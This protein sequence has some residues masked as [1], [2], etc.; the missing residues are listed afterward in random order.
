MWVWTIFVRYEYLSHIPS[1]TDT[2]FDSNSKK[3]VSQ[4]GERIILLYVFASGFFV[5]VH[6]D[7]GH[8]E[9][10]L[11]F[12]LEY[13]HFRRLMLRLT[14]YDLMCL[15]ETRFLYPALTNQVH[16][17]TVFL[18]RWFALIVFWT[19]L[20]Y[21]TEKYLKRTKCPKHHIVLDLE[22]TEHQS[23][24]FDVERNLLYILR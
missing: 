15:Q 10:W 3:M 8:K 16:R 5:E 9:G 12:L 20:T 1:I 18:P 22:H 14:K 17:G 23:L 7:H 24:C 11:F 21:E 4:Q 6:H 13:I 2:I 19:D